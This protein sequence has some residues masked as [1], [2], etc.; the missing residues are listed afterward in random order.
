MA[1]HT[2]HSQKCF[3][4]DSISVSTWKR[5]QFVIAAE[6][7]SSTNRHRAAH[8]WVCA[9]NGACERIYIRRSMQPSTSL[10]VKLTTVSSAL[11]FGP[12]EL[13]IP[14]TKDLKLRQQL[15][16]FNCV[17]S[18]L[19]RTNFG[20]QVSVTDIY[21]TIPCH[22]IPWVCYRRRNQWLRLALALFCLPLMWLARV[23]YLLVGAAEGWGG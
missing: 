5:L 12:I 23:V 6:S 10:A 2:S 17:I 9:T 4:V 7:G 18:A 15:Q 1:C 8:R 22:A 14:V 20:R 21:H 3:G 19:K 11:R 16:S 13:E